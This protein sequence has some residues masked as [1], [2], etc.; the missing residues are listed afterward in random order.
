[1]KALVTSADEPDGLRL[2]SVPEPRPAPG[3][4]LVEVHA[5]AVNRADLLLA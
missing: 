1:M 4:A 5:V 2:E 3:E